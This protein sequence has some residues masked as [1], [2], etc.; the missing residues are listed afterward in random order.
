MKV[1]QGTEAVL[2]ATYT[3]GPMQG[4]WAVGKAPAP[5]THTLP[6]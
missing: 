1:G 3:R 4:Q 5:R 6:V 2:L